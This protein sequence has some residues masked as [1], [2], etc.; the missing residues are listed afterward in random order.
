MS[1]NGPDFE[2]VPIPKDC[3]HN[4]HHAVERLLRAHAMEPP[5]TAV[6][7]P[8]DRTNLA[9]LRNNVGS[10]ARRKG[11]HVKTSIRDGKVLAWI[12][13]ESK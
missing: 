1:E 10:Q 3:A 11:L 7:S 8:L 12:V 2:Y 9:Y 13:Q 4:K 5:Q 6:F